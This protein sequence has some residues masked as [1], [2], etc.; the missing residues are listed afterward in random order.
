MFPTEGEADLDR[1][2]KCSFNLEHA[3]ESLINRSVGEYQYEQSF[4]I[5]YVAEADVHYGGFHSNHEYNIVK[6]EW[7]SDI[8][9]L[10]SF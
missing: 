6:E 4:H 8:L 5:S 10:V 1:V 2:L 7:G 9:P 3:I